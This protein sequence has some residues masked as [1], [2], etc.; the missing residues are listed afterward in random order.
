MGKKDYTLRYSTEKAV[1]IIRPNHNL[2]VKKPLN[3]GNQIQL[4]V[5]NIFKQKRQDCLLLLENYID[6]CDVVLLQEAQAT[7]ALF[8]FILGHKKVADQ[9][10]AYFFNDIYVGV[11]TIASSYPT[12]V[13]AFKSPEPLIRIPKS[14]LITC[15]KLADQEPQLLVA[16]IHAV[17]FSLGVKIYRQQIRALLNV[18]T[19]HQGP[20]ILA[21]DFNAWSRHRLAILYYLTRSIG[22][23]PVNFED[24]LRKTFMGR[25]LD[26]VFYRGLALD[27][28]EIIATESSDHNPLLVR[29]SY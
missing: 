17:N 5:W 26:F 18:I 24:D 21:G 12:Y 7:P 15:Y 8:N 3:M 22:L 11:M 23:K 19:E 1:E 29:F 25:P 4:L 28:A 2:L 27:R 9:V 16:N 14:A 13:N 10:P 6:Q 20:V